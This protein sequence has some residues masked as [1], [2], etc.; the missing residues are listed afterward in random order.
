[1][2]KWMQLWNK[3]ELHELVVLVFFIIGGIIQHDHIW[4]EWDV[5]NFSNF[6]Q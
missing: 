1:M 4:Y 3:S 2:H 5:E 6:P